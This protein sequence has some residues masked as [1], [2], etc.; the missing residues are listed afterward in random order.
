[1]SEAERISRE[2]LP[3]EP[4]EDWL[5]SWRRTMP[6]PEP[7]RRARGLDTA[8]PAQEVDWSS[9]IR[10]AILS[11]RSFMVEAVGGAL[12]E[13]R[14]EVLDEVEQLIAQAVEQI[15]SDLRAEVAGQ[16]AQLRSQADTLGGELRAALEKIIA[17]KQRARAARANGNGSTL[18]LPGPNGHDKARPQ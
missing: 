15:K 18:L 9:I 8:P 11:E 13:V 16:L 12:G 7:E 3:T 17:R 6:K 14:N 1:M 4:R 10:R 2:R 5:E